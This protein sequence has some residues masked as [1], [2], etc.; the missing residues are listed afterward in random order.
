MRP[1]CNS[2]SACCVVMRLT[3]YTAAAIDNTASAAL[4]MKMR[5]VSDPRIFTRSYRTV[6][7][8]SMGPPSSGMTMGLDSRIAPSF[9]ATSV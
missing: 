1:R 9:H 5:L 7:S 3:K 8:A 4:A 6:K 2:A